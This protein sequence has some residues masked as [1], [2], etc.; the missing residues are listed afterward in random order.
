MVAFARLMRCA[1]V[2]SVTRKASAISAVV[3]PPTARRVRA[4]A[5]GGVSDE[6]QARNSSAR[7]SSSPVTSGSSAGSSRNTR[8]S[9]ARREALLR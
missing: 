2:A 8:S 3:S 5:L 4:M 7:L 9:R 6:W 1:I